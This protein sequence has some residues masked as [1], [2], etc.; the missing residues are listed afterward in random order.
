MYGKTPRGRDPKTIIRIRPPAHADPS[1]KAS[2]VAVNESASAHHIV[3]H[4]Y[5]I[6][7]THTDTHI[8]N[9][10]VTAVQVYTLT[11]ETSCTQLVVDGQTT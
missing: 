3:G 5:R 7:Y 2:A 1:Q 4:D 6:G 11:T 10:N 8:S 9:R